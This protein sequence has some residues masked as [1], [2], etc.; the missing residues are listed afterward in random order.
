M[1]DWK[2]KKLL[3]LGATRLFVEIV[4]VAQRNG[5]H[6]TVIDNIENSP[7]KKIA[8]ESYLLSVADIDKVVDFIKEKNIDGVFTSF[9]DSLLDFYIKIC[10][11]A[12]LPCLVDEIQARLTSDKA[13]F[14]YICRQ[15][16]VPTIPEF[17]IS[18]KMTYPVLVKPVDSSGSRGI[19]TCYNDEE[20]EKAKTYALEYSKQKKIIIEKFMDCEEITISYTF[21]DG[22]ILLTSIHDRF[23]NEEQV[24][25]TK[26]PNCYIYPSKYLEKYIESDANKNMINMLHGLGF[27][28]GKIFLQAF[29]DDKGFYIYEPGVR[30]NGCKIYN[31]INEMCNY[32][33]LERM[34]NFSLTGSMGTPLLSE[35]A[36]PRFKRYATTLS[37]LVNPGTIG[38]I[39][40][41]EQINNLEGVIH[42]T[43][44]HNVGDTIPESYKGTLLQTILRVSYAA[45][46]LSDLIETIQKSNDTLKVFNEKG[47]NLLLTPYNPCELKEIYSEETIYAK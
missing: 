7:A 5:A 1:F 35:C 45:D 26:V 3:L 12:N 34:I 11:K 2:G 25:V 41:L 14:K 21:H 20:L 43:L 31:V 19:T 16:N 4:E 38:K 42:S 47:E 28:N 23:F 27:K 17:K 30:L 32:N 44:W 18:D 13:F 6:V 46:K 37:Y 39:E 24:G 29:A 22:D 33:E 40:G 9:N 10:K 15:Y 8:N 36:E